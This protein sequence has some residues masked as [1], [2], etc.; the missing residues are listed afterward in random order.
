VR[1]GRIITLDE[2]VGFALGVRKN[3]YRTVIL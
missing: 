1:K 3:V 2:A